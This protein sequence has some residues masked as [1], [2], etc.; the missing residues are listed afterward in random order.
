M[1]ITLS[2]L[3]PYFS[4]IRSQFQTVLSSYSSW[5]DEVTS[6]TGQLFLD[7]IAGI[8]DVNQ[9]SI[10]RAVQE[11][12]IETANSSSAV[13]MNTRF[14]GGRVARKSSSTVT[15][16]L[17][18]TGNTP[19][20]TLPAYS[21]FSIDQDNKPFINLAPIVFITNTMYNIILTEGQPISQSFISD[22][23]AFEIYTIGNNFDS[24]DTLC[25][26]LVN[27]IEFTR[28]TDS[29]INYNSLSQ[30]F[31]DRTTP[32]GQ[33]ELLL[34]NNINGVS[35]N[36]GDTVTAIN[37]L[38]RGTSINTSNSNLNVICVGNNL[39]TGTTSTAILGATDLLSLDT[40]KYISPRL[41][42]ANQRGVTRNDID[43]IV[44]TYPGVIDCNIVNESNI[45]PGDIR[46]MNL[47]GIV[48]I[49]SSSFNSSEFLS[50]YSTYQNMNT[51]VQLIVAEAVPI[52]IS[53]S[54]IVDSKFL[55]N[56]I[57]SAVINEIDLF[58]TPKQG[59][60]QSTFFPQD[61]SNSLYSIPGVKHISLLIPDNNV[62]ILYYQYVTS[63]NPIVNVSY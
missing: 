44:R 33:I 48:V 38:V 28:K 30:V 32:S 41:F 21:N 20:Y 7:F 53:V 57:Q 55:L 27:N 43:A 50:W 46:W 10:E 1:A 54:I 45:R 26:L 23:S 2:T 36:I 9:Y 39:I 12:F 29:L 47:T 15:V 31:I 16:T 58:M 60:L 4:N 11:S 34:G 19:N 49:E 14:L 61:L 63:I 6:S 8:G 42:A 13:Y 25:R 51:H 59:S 37:Y 62:E 5:K 40:Y 17:I 52:Q 24:S 35:P 22:G 3:V 18:Y 56:N